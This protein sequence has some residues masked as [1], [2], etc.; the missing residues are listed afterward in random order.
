M[1][2]PALPDSLRL[3]RLLPPTG[4]LRVVLDTDTYNEVDDQFAVAQMLLS[5]DRL[6]VEALYA[7]PF[8]NSR[9]N[10][11]ADGMEKSYEEILRLFRR[12][13][14]PPE[15]LVFR[16]ST[17]YLAGPYEAQESDA[18]RDLVDRAM[19]G[20]GL[21]YVA[22]IGAITNVAAAII[23]EPRIIERIVLVWLGGQPLH[24]PSAREFNLKQD[25]HASRLVFDCGVPLVLIPCQGVASHLQT[26][27]AELEHY[28]AGRGA[29]G[30]FL[31][32][33]VK[34]YSA[35]HCAWSKVIWDISVIGY[36]LEPRWVPTNLVPSP[37][38]TDQFTWS[39]DQSRH[40][41]RIATKVDR[42]PI[43]RDLFKKLERTQQ[44]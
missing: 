30:D 7:V 29:I 33:R 20:E 34:G 32:E 31:V 8:S 13:D 24:W 14:I 6:T 21:L 19:N 11:P 35:D 43:F 5:L 1:D 37:I 25:L 16:G 39:V 41:I 23:L 18:A 26:T 44:G 28:V 42:D 10:G 40:L 27:V 3:E 2:F 4:R 9:S 38:L 17:Q 22:A 12:L 15:G 36:L